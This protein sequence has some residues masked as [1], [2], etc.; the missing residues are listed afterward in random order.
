MRIRKKPWAKKELE[1]SQIFL[2]EPLSCTDI[3]SLFSKRHPVIVELGCG[4]GLFLAEYAASH[5]EFNFIGIDLKS[6]ILAVAH[7]NIA[8]SYRAKGAQPENILLLPHDIMQVSAL[9]FGTA[10]WEAVYIHFPNPWPKERHK[11]RRLTHPRQ[12]AQ[13]RRFL[14]SGGSLYFKT[15]DDALYSD[16]ITYFDES[17]FDIIYKTDHYYCNVPE[18]ERYPA[19][20]HEAM[21]KAEGKPIYYIK[22]KKR[23]VF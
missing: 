11:K 17:G 20:E 21:F 3:S 8:A 6:D 1:G 5:P 9:P 4:K 7:R 19:T 12:L 14:K 13:Y 2:P 15:D 10:Q 18:N 22:A 23:E 16:T